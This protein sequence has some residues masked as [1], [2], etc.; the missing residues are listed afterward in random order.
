MTCR[1]FSFAS[2]TLPFA[3]TLPETSYTAAGLFMFA[4]GDSSVGTVD[5][6]TTADVTL[7]IYRPNINKIGNGSTKI[8]VA[9]GAKFSTTSTAPDIN[10]TYNATDF[11]SQFVDAGAYN[12]YS[13]CWDRSLVPGNMNEAGGTFDARFYSYRHGVGTSGGPSGSFKMNAV[14]YDG[15]AELLTDADSANPALWAPSGTVI[16][17]SASSANAQKDVIAKYFGGQSTYLVP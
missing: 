6:V 9:D 7:P 3:G 12:S 15:H 11:A 8:F 14:F 4:S 5:Q 2:S 16:P 10:L 13:H 1:R 17:A